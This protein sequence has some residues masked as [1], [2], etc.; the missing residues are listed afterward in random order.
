[1]IVFKR[2]LSGHSIKKDSRK[3]KF[4]DKE[5]DKKEFYSS[6]Q[7][8]SLDSIDLSKIV[9]S[10]KCKINDTTY[11]YS[12]GYLNNDIIQP[13]C[14]I[15]PQMSGY[16]K[17]FGDGGKNM[18]FV[19]DDEEVYEKYNEIWEVVRNLLKVKFT[20]NP[21][22]D[23]KYIIAKLKMFNGTNRTTFT[24]NINPIERNNYICIA[25]IDIDSVLK[26]E[27]KRAYPQAYLEQCK[28]KLK[29]SNIVNFID[30]EI[31]DEEDNYKFI[32]GIIFTEE[33]QKINDELKLA[34]KDNNH[35]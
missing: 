16:I 26:I 21:I 1:M 35:I 20:V 12:C 6:K 22:R 28:Y 19:T 17:Y 32:D 29:K 8:I 4:R 7:A 30:Y 25:A 33:R 9:V 31:I 18:S 13:L 34:Q 10:N 15:L 5:V 11:K 24:N 14:V 3:I 2:F 23:D 27:N